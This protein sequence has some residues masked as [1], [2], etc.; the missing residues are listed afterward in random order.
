MSIVEQVLSQA[1]QQIEQSL[2][3]LFALMRIE[4]ISTDPAYKSECSAAADWLVSEL[5]DLGFDASARKT[6]GHPMVV[7]HDHGSD[8]GPHVL[9][10]GHYDVQPVDPI[11][12]WDR[13]PFEPGLIEGSDGRKQITGRGSSDDKGQLLTFVEACRAWKAVTGSLPV[14]VSILFEGEEESG[15]PSLDGFMQVNKDEL[16]ADIALVC[17]TTMWNADT[18]AITASLRGMMKENFTIEAASRDL[19][20]GF[21]GGLARNPLH[22]LSRIVADLH[23]E[24]GRVT[25]PDFYDGVPELTEAQKAEWQRLGF[26]QDAFLGDI[27]L[28]APASEPGCSGLETLWARPTCE[29]NGLWG[30]YNGEGS[31]TVIPSRANAKFSFRLV[32]DQDPV[33]IRKAFRN[34]VEERLPDDCTIAYDLDDES[35]GLPLIV[36]TDQPLLKKAQEAL[37]EE[38][39]CEA[40]LIGCGGSIPIATEFKRVLDMDTLLIGFALENDRIHS[41]NEKYELKSFQKGIRSWV[42]ILAN[43]A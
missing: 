28:S 4:S 43:L 39:N 32:G 22:L 23:D 42:R 15:S 18:P 27:G 37:A 6:P 3:R 17:D 35:D 19:H 12:L 7:G 25:I 38:W 11:E 10:Y 41:P 2:E 29:V 14:K 5:Q 9:F 8:N 24:N 21:Y 30:G 13:P 31:K 26:D 34:F 40:P 1:D 33:A 16:K 36:D 20:S